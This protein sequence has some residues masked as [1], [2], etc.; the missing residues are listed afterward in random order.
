MLPLCDG[1]VTAST[2]ILSPFCRCVTGVTAL[3]GGKGVNLYPERNPSNYNRLFRA[4]LLFS[5]GNSRK[6]SSR[7]QFFNHPLADRRAKEAE[8]NH[9]PNG[10]RIDDDF[11]NVILDRANDGAG[12]FFR[13]RNAKRRRCGITAGR[14][15]LGVNSRF[16]ETGRDDGGTDSGPPASRPKRCA[17]GYKAGS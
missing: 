15:E 5:F 12:D 9:R 16:D 8:D 14:L 3:D 4:F 1:F 10:Y 13:T 11:G 2:S 7:T 17:E 6:K